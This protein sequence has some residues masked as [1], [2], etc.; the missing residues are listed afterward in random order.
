[1]CRSHLQVAA[2]HACPVT[3]VQEVGNGRLLDDDVHR[4]FPLEAGVQEVL[5]NVHV[6]EN[7]HHYADELE[8]ISMSVI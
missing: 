4:H 5:E 3:H 1:M 6:G 8:S 7:V 2:V